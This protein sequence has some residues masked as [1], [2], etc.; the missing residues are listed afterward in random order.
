ML[1]SELEAYFIER[2]GELLNKKTPDSY[3]V[4]YHNS[5]SILQEFHE[6]I[7]GWQKRRIQSY[8]TVSLCAKECIALLEADQCL[9]FN[10]YDKGLFIKD[11]E[12]YISKLPDSK[13]KRECI[14]DLSS[15]VRYVSRKCVNEN[16]GIY[17]KNLFDFILNE[18]S[19]PGDM[20]ADNCF[21]KEMKV[22][23][24][25]TSVLCTELLRLGYSKNHL[26][27]KSNQLS[28]HE[29]TILELRNYFIAQKPS[30]YGVLFKMNATNDV[31]GCKD[32]Y[33]FTENADDVMRLLTNKSGYTP[34][35]SFFNVGDGVLFRKFEVSAL[36]TYSAIKKAKAEL[37]MLLDSLHFGVSTS[38]LMINNMVIVYTQA[39]TGYYS[40]RR[41]SEYKLDGEYFNDPLLSVRLKNDIG[42]ILESNYVKEDAKERLISALRHFRMAD[43][44]TDIELRFINLWVAL[45][46][47]FSSPVS[48][49]NTFLRIKKHLVNVLCCSYVR[50]NVN[51]LE[52][53]LVSDG[54]ISEGDVLANMTD[55]D[56]NKLI[57]NIHNKCAQYRLCCLK[58]HLHDESSISSYVSAHKT[59]LEW[60][61]SRIYRMRNELIHEA[62]IKQDI[63]AATSNL[64]F[65]L[66]LLLNQI[67]CY[68]SKADREMVLSINDFF[69]EYENSMDVIEKTPSREYLLS[70]E[71]EHNL[72]K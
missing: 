20:D 65:Y 69:H 31:I 8:E 42:K 58:S 16:T 28:K 12:D 33:G 26:Y 72:I 53:M 56:W 24:W 2:F 15:K 61:I 29:L 22:F 9:A 3:R 44:C 34:N 18:I 47:I 32:A 52:K 38:D 67:I 48:N 25:A 11:I 43:S 71:Y 14:Y 10:S 36:D 7:E 50:R 39:P 6:L 27:L 37:A 23:D 62:A 55:Q 54:A 41:N 51:Y 5:L 40:E 46:F 19:K 63:E 30:D 59:N 66:V 21:P 64:R 70:Y 60:H 1:Y 13:E 4:R 45:E 17:V 57:N 35:K 68:F 49:E